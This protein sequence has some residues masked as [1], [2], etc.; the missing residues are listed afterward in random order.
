[1]KKLLLLLG[2]LFMTLLSQA[3]T[4][5][6]SGRVT[7]EEGT[8]LRGVSVMI[9]DGKKG[10]QTD[11]NGNFKIETTGTGDASLVV[12]NTGFKSVTVTASSN[13]AI[14][15]KLEKDVTALDDI[16]VI[17][18]STVRRRDLT[19][20]VS[21]VSAKQ[22]KDVPISSAAEALQGRLAGVQ[23]ISSEGA[24]GAEI[25]IRVRGGGSITQDY[26][27]IGAFLH[28]SPRRC[29]CPRWTF[30]WV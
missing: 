14:T 30:I 24:P 5:Q 12:S 17:G 8:P 13:S 9:R 29:P 27:T 7:D 20:S 18:Y 19:G 15:V 1:M 21:S 4:R 28:Q 11:A 10:T 22:L 2:W 26:N 23:A 6:L 16:V 3:Q 25:I